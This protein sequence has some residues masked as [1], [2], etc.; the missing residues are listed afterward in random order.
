MATKSA[1][2]MVRVEPSIKLKA[3]NIL[4]SLG[5]NASTV[6]N[7]LYHQIIYTKSVPFSLSLPSNIP[8]VEDMSKEEFNDMLNSGLEQAAKGEGE[9]LGSA[10]NDI[11]GKI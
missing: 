3:D 11:R 7:A 10:F 2:V 5:V 8:C 4:E 6:I 9:D 1:N